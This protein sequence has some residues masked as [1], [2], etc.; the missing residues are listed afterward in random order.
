VLPGSL[1]LTAIGTLPFAFTA[2][3]VN[4]VLLDAALVVRGMGLTAA[5]IAVMAGAYRDLNPDQVPHASAVTRIAQLAGASFGTAVL[6]AILAWQLTAYPAAAAAYGHTFGWALGFTLTAFIPALALPRTGGGPE[7]AVAGR[8]AGPA[9]SRR[10]APQAPRPL[11]TQLR[12][13][14]VVPSAASGQHLPRCGVTRRPDGGLG[15]ASRSGC[16]GGR[17]STRTRDR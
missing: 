1:A 7:G 16:L 14:T 17:T 13:Q 3:H 15:R 8:P 10:A 5:N 4:A 2:D 11:S 9:P 12:L 6:A